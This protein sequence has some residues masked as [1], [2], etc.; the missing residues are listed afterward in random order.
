MFTLFR[1]FQF[2]NIDIPMDDLDRRWERVADVGMDWQHATA[3]KA[4]KHRIMCRAIVPS[5]A[6]WKEVHTLN[7]GKVG[8]L[9]QHVDGMAYN[10]SWIDIKVILVML[11]YN[12]ERRRLFQSDAYLKVSFVNIFVVFT[13]ITSDNL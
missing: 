10:Q 4:Q 12:A 1:F 5:A 9:R 2:P 8:T 6:G 7:C 3:L 13:E 11:H